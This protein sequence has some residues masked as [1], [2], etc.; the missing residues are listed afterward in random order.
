MRKIDY[1]MGKF[2]AVLDRVQKGVNSLGPYVLG[3][4]GAAAA[5]HAGQE[6]WAEVLQ[7][8]R[9]LENYQF[10]IG[11]GAFNLGVLAP[12]I[13]EGPIHYLRDIYEQS[14][15]MVYACTDHNGVHPHGL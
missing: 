15:G 3:N 9:S 13:R 1:I 4:I 10:Y 14:M 6:A 2:R 5:L 8:P 12:S 11:M 7:L